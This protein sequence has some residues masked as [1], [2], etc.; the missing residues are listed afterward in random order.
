MSN[1]KTRSRIASGF[2]QGLSGHFNYEAIE[3][4][5]INKM[6]VA[7]Y[8]LAI[9]DKSLLTLCLMEYCASSNGSEW[10]RSCCLDGQRST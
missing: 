2:A 1:F 4:C 5:T 9:I 7:T 3:E 8:K 10:A 6:F